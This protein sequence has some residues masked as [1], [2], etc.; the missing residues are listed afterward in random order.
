[1]LELEQDS[2]GDDQSDQDL[3]NRTVQGEG[4]NDRVREK[5]GPKDM[6]TDHEDDQERSS[7]E[8]KGPQPLVLE[9]HHL[10]PSSALLKA[11]IKPTPGKEEERTG[12]TSSVSRR[13]NP[14]SLSSATRS[15]TLLPPAG[16][17]VARPARSALC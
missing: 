15:C 7:Y 10:L 2:S 4:P 16:K 13:S 14:A 11:Q 3:Q 8:E 12:G 9:R 6:N 1:M 5:H 17:L